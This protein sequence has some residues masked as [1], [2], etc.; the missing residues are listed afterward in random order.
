MS[1]KWD[2]NDCVFRRV[3]KTENVGAKHRPCLGLGLKFRTEAWA[4]ERDFWLFGLKQVLSVICGMK[5]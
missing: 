4:A 2:I 1:V 3:G 5:E